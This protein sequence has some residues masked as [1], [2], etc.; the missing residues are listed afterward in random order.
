NDTIVIAGDFSIKDTDGKTWIED[1]D[2]KDAKAVWETDDTT[3][4]KQAV[5]Y[6]YFT[7]DGAEKFREA[8]EQNL[9]KELQMWVG[10]ML[11]ESAVVNAVIENGEAC[12]YIYGCD[13]ERFEELEKIAAA[14]RA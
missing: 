9:G 8:T 2:V 14:T 13:D 11:L 6:I 5:I 12:V 10:T 7:E 3:G 4:E 1:A